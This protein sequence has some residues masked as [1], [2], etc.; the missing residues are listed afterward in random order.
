VGIVLTGIISAIAEEITLTTYYPAPTGEY[1]DLEAG[2]LTLTPG[3][4]PPVATNSELEGMFYYDDGTGSNTEGLYYCEANAGGWTLLGGG[5]WTKAANGTDIYY[6]VSEGKVGIG[7]ADPDRMFHLAGG[8][9]SILLENIDGQADYK[10]MNIYVDGPSDAPSGLVFRSIKDDNTQQL[11]GIL[12]IQADGN[13]GIGETD[14][15]AK[16]HIGGT[17]GTDGI[18]FP[19]GTT[20]TTSAEAK[21]VIPAAPCILDRLYWRFKND[22]KY[23]NLT[24]TTTGAVHG[25]VGFSIAE[26]QG[27]L[28]E[29]RNIKT[30]FLNFGEVWRQQGE[31]SPT[32][33]FDWN[34]LPFTGSNVIT[35]TIV[36]RFHKC[37][38][39]ITEM[40]HLP[41]TLS[42][43]VYLGDYDDNTERFGFGGSMST[44][45]NHDLDTYYWSDLYITAYSVE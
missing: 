18:M 25:G 26:V 16:L 10:R 8:R 1:N 34:F 3:S 33:D 43:I 28:G 27:V 41:Y 24:K 6:D 45:K 19:D 15:Q 7:T 12:A 11:D 2:V 17:A 9:P 4:V 22:K 44:E 32:G 38:Q 30:L 37:R 31:D 40:G 21:T 39:D 5:A 23:G 35:S 20:Q 36:G 13:V 14:P 29:T 42:F